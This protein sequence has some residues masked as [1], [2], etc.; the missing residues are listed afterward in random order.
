MTQKRARHII[1]SSLSVVRDL[2]SIWLYYVNFI[3]QMNQRLRVIYIFPW[4]RINASEISSN[5]QKPMRF[6]RT[7]YQVI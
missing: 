4:I 3:P 1:V 7:L 5:P 6:G 2:P